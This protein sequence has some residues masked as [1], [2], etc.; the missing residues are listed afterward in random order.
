MSRKIII[1]VTCLAFVAGCTQSK[2]AQIVLKGQNNYALGNND[3][4]I[5]QSQI[6]ASNYSSMATSGGGVDYLSSYDS[7]YNID[8]FKSNY[9]NSYVTTVAENTGHHAFV[10]SVGV[11]DLASP[12][13]VSN[14][15]KI[16]ERPEQNL[17]LLSSEQKGKEVVLK[18]MVDK[19]SSKK[20]VYAETEKLIR[21]WSTENSKASYKPDNSVFASNGSSS[22]SKTSDFRWPLA[23]GKVISEFGAKGR[24]KASE[25]IN[26]M[27]ERGDPVWAAAD[28]EVVYVGDKLKGYGKMVFIKHSGNKTTGYAHLSHIIVDKYERVAQGDII[29]Y[30]GNSGDVNTPQLF[31]SLYEGKNPVNPKKYL[32]HDMA[33]L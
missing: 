5:K 19:E 18:P 14:N 6:T 22:S 1:L 4:H 28:G 9:S 24:G 30:A 15:S 32:S 23:G 7:S 11:S 25:G 17:S 8:N 20:E 27:T 21:G 16:V 31:F 12:V 3:S 13:T 2:P 33:G 26:I 10:G 29:G